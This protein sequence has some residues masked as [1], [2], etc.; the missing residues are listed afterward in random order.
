MHEP[1]TEERVVA[2]FARFLQ[3]HRGG[4][5]STELA[6]ALNELVEAVTDTGKAGSLSLTVKIKPAGKGDAHALFVSDDV[7]V[8]KPAAERG[9][10][11][12][13]A[14]SDS[15]LTRKDPRQPEIPGLVEVP[16]PST[17]TDA[18]EARAQ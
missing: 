9:E 3:E 2:P 1:E 4:R 11:L 7:K 13:F 6:E 15:N 5:L 17:A 18:R 12:F 14:D 10:S 16:R 8:K